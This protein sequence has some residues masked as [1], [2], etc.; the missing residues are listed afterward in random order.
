MS[1]SSDL[2]LTG[3]LNLKT[4]TSCFSWHVSILFILYILNAY[5]TV[6]FMVTSVKIKGIYSVYMDHC[7]FPLLF[8]GI[9]L[10]LSLKNLLFLAAFLQMI[11][12]DFFTTSFVLRWLDSRSLVCSKLKSNPLESLM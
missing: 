9:C 8:V 4:A 3:Q 7:C 2:V 6:G 10:N 12:E 11:E 5:F 1:N